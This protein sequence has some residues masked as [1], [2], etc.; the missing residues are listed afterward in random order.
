MSDGPGG[1]GRVT[2]RAALRAVGAAGVVGAAAACGAPPTPAAT[3]RPQ[4]VPATGAHVAATV[5]RTDT[6]R[7]AVRGRD[8]RLVLVAPAGVDPAALPVCVGLHGLHG[9]SAW[10][11]ATGMRDVLGAAW[12]AGTPPFVV[13]APDGGDNYWHRV[14]P[15]DDPMRMLLDELPGWL[16]DRG[17]GRGAAAPDLVAGVSMGGAGALLYARERARR[18]VPVRAAAAL[19]PGLFTDWRVASLRPYDGPADWAANDPLRSVPELAGTPTGVWVG[20]RDPF[21]AAT[22]RYI[23]LARPEVGS[24]TSGAHDGTFY[25]SVLPAVARFLGAHVAGLPRRTGATVPG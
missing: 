18:G 10:W 14:H 17:L 9:T 1:P 13:A 16:A 8:V 24:V 12:T 5:A 4:A 6:V 7:S 19:S 20:Q 11:S 22:R 2:R 23:A 21:V 25:A 3:A 15:G